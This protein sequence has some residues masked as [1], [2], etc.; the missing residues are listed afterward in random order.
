MRT[1]HVLFWDNAALVRQLKEFDGK[2]HIIDELNNRTIDISRQLKDVDTL[3]VDLKKLEEI[4]EPLT[5][6][7]DGFEVF[8]S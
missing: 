1:I 3:M 2:K 5:K 8:K 4:V 7:M 6:L